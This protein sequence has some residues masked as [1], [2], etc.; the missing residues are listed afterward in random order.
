MSKLLWVCLGGA[1]GSGARYLVGL[2]AARIW[3]EELPLGTLAA[4][5]IGCLLMGVLTAYATERPELSPELRAALGAGVL[6]G[7][8]T[9]SA[10]NQQI[11]DLWSS[12]A[13]RSAAG[14]ALVTAI[15]CV[16]AGLLGMALAKQLGVAR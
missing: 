6:G 2:G 10:F 5:V 13:Q 1:L 3:G 12:G 16:A 4:N 9:Y 8:T 11:L 15:F 7:L 14:Y